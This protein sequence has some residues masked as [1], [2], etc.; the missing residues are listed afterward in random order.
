[1]KKLFPLILLLLSLAVTAFASMQGG[2]G[3]KGDTGAPGGTTFADMIDVTAAPYSAVCDNS[4]DTTTAIQAAFNAATSEQ[5]VVIPEGTCKTTATLTLPEDINLL[6]RGCINI[7]GLA[8]ETALVLGAASST[9]FRVRWEGI[10]VSRNLQSDWTNEANIGVVLRN[11]NTAF[12][13]I[14]D[15]RGFTIGVRMLGQDVG[16]SYNTVR[17][18][19]L[20]NNK[21]GLDLFTD[22][23]NTDGFVTE[24][25]FL[26]GRFANSDGVN[27]G[28]ARYGVRVAADNTGTDS[29]SH[30]SNI[31]LKPAFE[32]NGGAS[33]AGAAEAIPVLLEVGQLHAFIQARSEG[34]DNTVM[35]ET[36]G[37]LLDQVG[38]WFDCS[39]CDGDAVVVNSSSGD[40]RYRVSGGRVPQTVPRLTT[41]ELPSS[42]NEGM[43]VFD[44]TTNKLKVYVDDGTPS[45]GGL[46][47]MKR[48]FLSIYLSLLLAIPAFASMQGGGAANRPIVDDFTVSSNVE[49]KDY[50]T[51]NPNFIGTGWTEA[52]NTSAASVVTV[53]D[54][55]DRLQAAPTEAG[56]SLG[57]TEIIYTPVPSP[58]SANYSV[59]ITADARDTGDDTFWV[60]CRYVADGGYF[61]G[62]SGTTGTVFIYENHATTPVL[63]F[64]AA[65]RAIGTGDVIEIRCD[66]TI[67]TGWLNGELVAM[68]SD[69]TFTAAGNAAIA[70]GNLFRAADDLTNTWVVD[71]FDV[72]LIGSGSILTL[73]YDEFT[74][75]SDTALDAH[76]PTNDGSGWTEA[77]DTITTTVQA[78]ATTNT[79]T[80]GW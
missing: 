53:L 3:V 13:S 29:V 31:F 61:F 26:G 17:L 56:I 49:L 28:V 18:G 15:V 22:G 1:M 62:G 46:E 45:M 38:N 20:L 23:G 77:D 51:E 57:D 4:A 59:K 5:T 79:I 2:G 64:T 16:N 78:I 6:M 12:I 68:A 50:D 40:D 63:L 37:A 54:S 58:T 25:L 32:I 80:H 39:N 34:N 14:R 47:L 65:N 27:T 8:N 33:G 41:S 24:N 19:Y 11:P 70:W 72:S 75:S 35:K 9:S 55:G 52:V 74:V 44:T 71:D 36:G 30:G 48:I 67:I 69:S 42:P 76:E 21:Y 10:C 60:G 66:G 7:D 73:V 43:L